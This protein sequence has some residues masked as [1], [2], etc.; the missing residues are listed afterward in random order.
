MRHK[1]S[2]LAPDRPHWLHSEDTGVTA[3]Y[4]FLGI[5]FMHGPA[6][7]KIGSKARSKLTTWLEENLLDDHPQDNRPTKARGLSFLEI[8]RM[9]GL[10]LWAQQVTQ[11]LV[12]YYYV[13]KFFRRKVKLFEKTM[14]DYEL[15]MWT[16]TKRQWKLWAEAL[17][18][19]RVVL[20]PTNS[21]RNT[22]TLTTD[23]SNSGF[24]AVLRTPIGVRVVSGKWTE[25]ES[26]HHINMKELI[27]LRIAIVAFTHELQEASDIHLV[28][29]NT[30]VIGRFNRL[31]PP[32]SFEAAQEIMRIR[33]V[34]RGIRT[35]IRYI[36]S[37]SNEADG[38]SR[39]KRYTPEQSN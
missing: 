11:Q 25:K 37:A 17:L 38:L 3:S 19:T 26:A 33:R 1:Q 14:Q 15:E 27:A 12:D 36:K 10:C 28:V 13:I 5:E 39:G 2:P 29:G 9:L 8:E 23:A 22:Y 20:L 34:V 18:S 31:C 24:G 35:T 4:T 32:R 16:D 7:V 6:M 21:P 30:S